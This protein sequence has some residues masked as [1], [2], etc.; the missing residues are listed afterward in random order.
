M[1]ILRA[2][3]SSIIGGVMMSLDLF[4]L[5][6]GG[7]SVTMPLSS[8]VGEVKGLTKVAWLNL[9][10]YRSTASHDGSIVWN[11]KEAR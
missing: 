5:S 6:L 10:E 7:L 3:S 1:S 8:Q 9:P 2:K 11:S 4:L